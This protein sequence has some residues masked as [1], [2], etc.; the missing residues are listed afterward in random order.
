MTRVLDVSSGPRRLRPQHLAIRWRSVRRNF[1]SLLCLTIRGVARL[2]KYFA[3]RLWRR[4]NMK[5]Q[6]TGPEFYQRFYGIVPSNVFIR[7][8]YGSI[9]SLFLKISRAARRIQTDRRCDVT[10]LNIH[11]TVKLN[12]ACMTYPISLHMCA[13]LLYILTWVQTSDEWLLLLLRFRDVHG[14]NRGWKTGCVITLRV[15]G[16]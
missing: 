6:R 10:E 16:F 2:I 7:Q 5:C 8:L 4:K 14:S 9:L 13:V 3:T 1:S 12:V 11:C 15:T